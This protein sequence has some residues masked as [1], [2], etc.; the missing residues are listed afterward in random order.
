MPAERQ[1]NF[2][3]NVR[4]PIDII[5]RRAIPSWNDVSGML[6]LRTQN[7][8]RHSFFLNKYAEELRDYYDYIYKLATNKPIEDP[9]PILPDPNV[10][11]HFRIVRETVFGKPEKFSAGYK[12]GVRRRK[13]EE[14]SSR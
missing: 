5:Q 9:T 10:A 6:I 14:R 8:W 11:Y 1:E 2:A 4:Q 3:Q 7:N 12:K 13:A